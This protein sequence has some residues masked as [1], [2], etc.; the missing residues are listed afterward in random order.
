[1]S[2]PPRNPRT[3]LRRALPPA[4]GP[5]EQ[6]VLASERLGPWRPWTQATR[7]FSIDSGAGQ[8]PDSSLPSI[9]QIMFGRQPKSSWR[10]AADLGG[11]AS[12]GKNS[13]HI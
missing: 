13:A 11:I 1:M 2:D 12:S 3:S 8:G 7:D 5:E 6:R 9:C 4:S 10:T